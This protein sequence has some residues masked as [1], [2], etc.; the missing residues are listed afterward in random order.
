V[1]SAK[2]AATRAA[3]RSRVTAVARELLARDGAA[4]LSLREV[5]REMGQTSSALYRYF[6]NRD[7]LLTALILDAYNDLGAAVERAEG[8]VD[9][10]DRRERWRASCRAARRWAR[11][12]PH[13]YALIFGSPVPGYEAPVATVAA[14]SRVTL[15]LAS[16]VADEYVGRRSVA[17]PSAL[18]RALEWD[19]VRVAMPGVPPAIAVRAIMAWTQLFGALTFELFGHYVGTVR[20]ASRMFELTVDE[21]ADL[22]GLSGGSRR[23]TGSH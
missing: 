23:S 4:G 12:H 5:A 18:A 7:E 17:P 6:A 20:D 3:N 22:V 16:I 15:V 8:K 14:A 2:R 11:A 13:E 10:G 19:A 1:E 9:R 21:M